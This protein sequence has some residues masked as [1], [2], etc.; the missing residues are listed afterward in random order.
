MVDT[1]KS[2][3]QNPER[4]TFVQVYVPGR[5][6]VIM[7]VDKFDEGLARIEVEESRVMP[8][9]IVRGTEENLEWDHFYSVVI[10]EDMARTLRSEGT[11]PSTLSFS[12]QG[13][14]A[15]LIQHDDDGFVR[16]YGPGTWKRVRRFGE[17]FI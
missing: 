14:G 12:I 7:D 8:C 10:D 15:L 9:F 1:D 11:A 3:D 13:G 16:V 2:D 5:G 6:L 17:E 4:V